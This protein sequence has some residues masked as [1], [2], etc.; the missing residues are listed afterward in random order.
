VQTY[1]RSPSQK[2][3]AGLFLLGI[4]GIY[5]ARVLRTYIAS[6]AAISY[7]IADLER[8]VHLAPGNAEYAHALG[9]QLSTSP[10]NYP[11][12]IASLERAVALNPQNGAYWLDLASV[13]QL[14]GQP[15]RQHEALES[16][17][18]AEPN[19]PDV[20]AE[21][22]NYFLAGGDI[23]RSL[24]L[25]RRT[26][27]QDP[28]AAESLLPVFWRATRDAKMLLEYA[29]PPDP[30]NRLVFLRLATVQN[31]P[32][33]A[34]ETWEYLLASKQPFAPQQGFFYFEYLIHNNNVAE[35]ARSWSAL[36]RRANGVRDYQ[37]GENRVVNGGF[38]LPVLNA[39]L[40][41]RYEAVEH[42]SSS[43]EQAEAHSGTR[44][45]RLVYD[46]DASYDAGWSQYVLVEP[47]ATYE[48]AAWIKSSDILSSSGPRFAIVDPSTGATFFLSDDVLDTHPWQKIQGQVQIPDGVS[49]AEIKITR[50]PANSKIRGEVIV[51]DVRLVRK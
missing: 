34:H 13:C 25:L 24:S 44:A 19:N 40:D 11:Q 28:A 9:L 14:A 29:I 22:A 49:L 51:D 50:A 41:W 7:R 3:V 36:G 38:E 47:G 21:A 6:T 18:V 46:G 42:V 17:L 48:F 20:S 10:E 31:D 1:L 8:V 32:T 30:D 33:A 16:A 39:G 15:Q 35:L 2:I 43:I 4:A 45:L 26:L 5:G 12:A 37:P 23:A 27:E